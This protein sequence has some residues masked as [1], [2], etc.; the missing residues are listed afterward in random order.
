MLLW[1]LCWHWSDRLGF[2]R[3]PREAATTRSLP[4]GAVDA[5]R[6]DVP[7]LRRYGSD[8]MSIPVGAKK[9]NMQSTPNNAFILVLEIIAQPA[10]PFREATILGTGTKLGVS[11]RYL[12]TYLSYLSQHLGRARVAQRGA[13]SSSSP[14]GAAPPL[15]E[16]LIVDGRASR[17]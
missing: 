13:R 11:W 5:M 12:P 3:E 14:V 6:C 4:S 16:L 15:T 7:T 8:L 1:Y 2:F 17:L 10:T 9:T